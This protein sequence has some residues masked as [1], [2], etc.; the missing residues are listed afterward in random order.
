[1]DAM[2]TTDDEQ[3][4]MPMYKLAL[5]GDSGDACC[6]AKLRFSD[7]PGADWCGL[8][9]LR[10][11]GVGKTCILLRFAEGGFNVSFMSTVG[12]VYIFATLLSQV[13]G[14]SRESVSRTLSRL[15]LDSLNLFRT[16]A[17]STTK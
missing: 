10:S 12:C 1:M 4:S 7:S 11:A 15:R 3:D 6:F 5:V 16:R 8:L 17:A 9:C 14:L 13:T 2:T